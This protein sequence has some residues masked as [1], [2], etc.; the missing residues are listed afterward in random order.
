M[1]GV[2]VAGA[3]VTGS[4]RVTEN[5][6]SRA[7][8]GGETHREG[9][10]YKPRHTRTMDGDGGARR[11]GGSARSVEDGSGGGWVNSGP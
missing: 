4:Q 9:V 7:R 5:R 1:V 8:V 2:C 10:K 6:S 3:G 11:R